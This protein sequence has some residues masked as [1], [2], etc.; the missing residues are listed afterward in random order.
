MTTEQRFSMKYVSRRTGLTPHTIRVW[1]RR[2]GAVVPERTETKRR[3]YSEEDIERLILLRRGVLAGHSIGRIAGLPPEELKRLVDRESGTG[4]PEASV[5]ADEPDAAPEEKVVEALEAVSALDQN[6]LERI[7]Y[8][9]AAGFSRPV[10]IERFI[11]PFL[12]KIGE[13]WHQGALRIAQEHFASFILRGFLAGLIR[14]AH[15]P[16][17]APL[18]LVA[19]PAGQHHEFGALFAAA[20]AVSCGWRGLYL[21]ANVPAEE[22]AGSANAKNVR[23]IALSLL[24][25][26]GDPRVA[27]E[28]EILRRCLNRKVPVIAGG[29]AAGSYRSVLDSIG[30]V[31]LQ[32]I[33]SLCSY[34]NALMQKS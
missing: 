22:I 8:Q 16:E 21:G 25:P 34:L 18:L 12:E 1:E 11:A 26:A 7:L 6:R 30:G 32:D 19:T 5:T 29:R 23:A 13:Q 17:T 2:Y 27:E 15:V 33:G 20:T 3:L 9:A 28:L 31:I 14:Q 10:L 24:H 4:S